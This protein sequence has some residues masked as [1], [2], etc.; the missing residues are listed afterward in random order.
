MTWITSHSVSVVTGHRSSLGPE[1]VELWSDPFGEER[2]GPWT[3]ARHAL[4]LN[5]ITLDTSTICRWLAHYPSQKRQIGGILLNSICIVLSVSQKKLYKDIFYM[6]LIDSYVFVRGRC[7]GST[8]KPSFCFF[9]SRRVR[10]VHS[11]CMLLHV[12]RLVDR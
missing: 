5:D 12:D 10:H 1:V 7:W 2:L 6:I 4:P 9:P 3:T 8:W 11:I